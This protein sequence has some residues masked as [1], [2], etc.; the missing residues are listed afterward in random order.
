MNQKPSLWVTVPARAPAVVR[1]SADLL[2]RHWQRREGGQVTI[3]PAAWDG[4]AGTGGVRLAVSGDLPAEAFEIRANAG[5]GVEIAGGDPRGVLYGVG[6]FLRTS[7]RLPD[8]TVRCTWQGRSV[9]AKPLRGIYFATHFHN[10][11]HDGP[12]AAVADYVEDLALWGTN[13]LAV[14][15]DMHHYNGIDDPAAQAMIRRLKEILSAGRRAGMQVGLVGL[16]NEAYANS[17]VELRA[18]WT[19]GHDGYHH[20]PGGHYHVELCPSKPGGVELTLRWFEEKLDAFA[21][22][23]PDFIWLWPYDQGGCTCA[24]CAPWGVN[25]FLRLAAPQAARYK[26][27]VPDGK[28]I[29]ST[30]YFDHFTDGEWNGLAE[31]FRTPPPGVDYVLADDYGDRFPAYPRKHGAPG[32]LPMVNFP[33]I[34]MY[35]M[36]PW[37]GYGAN[38]LP[39][40]LHRIWESS[41]RLLSG[42]FPYSEGIFE[43]INKALCAQFYWQDSADPMAIVREYAAGEFSAEVADDVVRAVAII[44][45]NHAR[46]GYDG[47]PNT[48]C[49]LAHS[50]GA[51]EARSLLETADRRLAE[52]VRTGWRWRILLLRAIIDAELAAGDGQV[53]ERCEEAFRELTR[54]Y[55]AAN[56]EG[57]VRP[58]TRQPAR[59]T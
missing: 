55:H 23:R 17:P 36:G 16:A 43:D 34:S 8:G 51:G 18:D 9:P 48:R 19:A 25:G 20:E 44:E 6:K 22:V 46:N 27:R 53:T 58:P 1:K 15:F 21:D 38:P 54:I 24:A 3:S 57:A 52:T 13:A 5:G 11:Y 31:A 50:E 40:H 42:G 7:Q 2:S 12:T 32:N 59:A 47:E 49:R 4:A 39:T 37:G 29:L 28:V 41:R 30:W 26:A 10:Y 14:W 56:A 35:N 33:E 45:R